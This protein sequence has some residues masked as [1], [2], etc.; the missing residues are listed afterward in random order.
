MLQLILDR[1]SFGTIVQVD[2]FANS[3]LNNCSD[4]E[5]NHML[6]ENE[7]RKPDLDQGWNNIEVFCEAIRCASAMHSKHSYNR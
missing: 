7:H 3:R 5:I 1:R 4:L 6:T 2:A